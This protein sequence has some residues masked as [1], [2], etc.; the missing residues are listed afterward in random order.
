M[1]KTATTRYGETVV[2][3]EIRD[4]IVYT[5]K[6]IYHITKLTIKK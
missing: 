5:D 3:F 1:H 4:N 2:I 6:G